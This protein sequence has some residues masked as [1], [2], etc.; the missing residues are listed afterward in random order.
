[1][2]SDY[3]NVLDNNM[4]FNVL[5]TYALPSGIMLRYSHCVKRYI[6]SPLSIPLY[7]IV[8][9]KLFSPYNV[10][11]DRMLLRVKLRH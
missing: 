2:P 10:G 6:A 1:M 11:S 7:N 4:A 3:T 8:L 5:C 9:S